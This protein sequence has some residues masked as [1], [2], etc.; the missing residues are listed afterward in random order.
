[1]FKIFIG[2]FLKTR[3]FEMARLCLKATNYRMHKEKKQLLTV[4]ENCRDC[5]S[6]NL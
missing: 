1:M 5:I 4:I 2:N 3:N 6:I